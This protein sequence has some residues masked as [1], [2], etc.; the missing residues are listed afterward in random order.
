MKDN[1]EKEKNIEDEKLSE[2]RKREN[3]KLKNL[4][5]NQ[6]LMNIKDFNSFSVLECGEEDAEVDLKTEKNGKRT[7]KESKKKKYPTIKIVNRSPEKHISIGDLRDVV[8]WILGNMSTPSWITATNKS[9]IKKIVVL[10]IPGLDPTLFNLDTGPVLTNSPVLLKESVKLS[11]Q[12][13]FNR[14]G[15][16]V[17]TG[18]VSRLKRV[19]SSPDVVL[20]ILGNMSTPSWITA[21]VIFSFLSEKSL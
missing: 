8:L 16:F 20:W 1:V 15:E 7:K 13:S 12:H 18:P 9:S 5:E 21:T 6:V 17:S 10:L 14:T 3:H 2:K 4:D 19:G 11:G